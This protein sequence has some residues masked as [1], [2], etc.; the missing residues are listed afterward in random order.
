MFMEIIG[1]EDQQRR[2]RR[3]GAE[4]PPWEPAP[5]EKKQI[6]RSARKA[7]EKAVSNHFFVRPIPSHQ[8]EVLKMNLEVLRG[9]IDAM[10]GRLPA[11]RDD[12][13][14]W[15][16]FQMDCSEALERL[17]Y[18]RGCIG[19]PLSVIKKMATPAGLDECVKTV[20]RE[21]WKKEIS[22]EFVN[23]LLIEIRNT[24]IKI[25]MA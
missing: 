20:H 19:S 15:I 5:E 22:F 3:I 25:W 6:S 24:R 14:Q 1:Q 13:G 8:A 21:V 11:I 10:K 18:I 23:N 9:K 4:V 17:D 16:S 2:Y 7:V 12:P